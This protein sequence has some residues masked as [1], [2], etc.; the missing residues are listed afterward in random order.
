MDSIRIGASVKRIA[1]ND[2]PERLIVFDPSDVA[3]AERFYALIKDF[4]TK[5]AEYQA[6]A[7]EIDRAQE[8]DAYGLPENLEKRLAFLREA[9]EYMRAQIDRVFGAGTSQAAFGDTLSLEMVADLFAGLTPFIQTA[10]SE[11]LKQYS[12]APKSKGK[13]VMR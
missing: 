3:F 9:C 7:E 4:E 2:D 8:T 5:Q 12:P 10:R 13:R 1:V 11:K 6:R